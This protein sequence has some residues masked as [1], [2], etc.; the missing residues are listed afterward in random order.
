MDK[1]EVGDCWIGLSLT[2]SSGLILTVRVGKHTD[3][4]ME[5]L[6]NNTEGKT[7]CKQVNSDDW[8]GYERVLPPE[9]KHH[10]G[11]DKTQRCSNTSRLRHLERSFPTKFQGIQPSNRIQFGLNRKVLSDVLAYQ[12][13]CRG[14]MSI[15]TETYTKAENV[16]GETFESLVFYLT[17][18]GTM[19]CL[20]VLS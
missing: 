12:R 15:C 16:T 18:G 7:D 8:G 1:P 10:I 9:I 3:A 2:N 17:T 4:L 20:A 11:K 19:S 14:Q 13:H 5:Q 6:V